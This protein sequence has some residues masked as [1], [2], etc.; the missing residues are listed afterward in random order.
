MNWL[1]ING[2]VSPAFFSPD[3]TIGKYIGYEGLQG[4]GLY[5]TGIKW[6]IGLWT[7]NTLPNNLYYPSTVVTPTPLTRAFVYN[8]T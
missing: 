1:M 2:T 5:W 8:T 3:Y 7:T 4:Q 6:S